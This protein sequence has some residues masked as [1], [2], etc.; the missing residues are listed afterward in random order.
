MILFVG[1]FLLLIALLALATIVCVACAV[2]KVIVGT[3]SQGWRW[4]R[5]GAS[6]FGID[7]QVQTPDGTFL[8][9]EIDEVPEQT[10]KIDLGSLPPWLKMVAG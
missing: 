7:L 10:V 8:E 1:A 2:A 3:F 6:E 5:V 4:T 9:G